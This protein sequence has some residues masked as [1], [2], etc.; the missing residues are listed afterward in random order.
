M[1]AGWKRRGKLSRTL[2]ALM[3]MTR[4]PERMVFAAV[5]TYGKRVG[6]RPWGVEISNSW[7]SAAAKNVVCAS[8]VRKTVVCENC[9]P[10]NKTHQFKAV[11]PRFHDFRDDFL[12][13]LFI[14][15]VLIILGPCD[16]RVTGTM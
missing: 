5:L 11:H 4:A 7:P 15:L 9:G 2:P 8:I 13:V 3:W 1:L 6:S 10:Y 14:H 12:F 16:V